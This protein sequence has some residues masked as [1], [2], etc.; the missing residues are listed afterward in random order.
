[1]YDAIIVGGGPA[2][3]SAALILG[4]CLRTVLLIDSGRPR[5]AWSHGVHGYLSRDGMDP[6]AFLETCH[7]ELKNYPTVNFLYAEVTEAKKPDGHFEI[8]TRDGDTFSGR[9]LLL[10]TGVVDCIPK[11]EGIASLYGRSVFNCPYCDAF[12]MRGKRILVYGQKERGKNLALTLRN[13]SEDVILVT[14]GPCELGDEDKALLH[15]NGITFHEGKIKRLIGEEGQLTHVEF[16]S[17]ET[18]A[19]DCMFFN[20]ESFL[21]SRLLD[22]LGCPFDEADGVPTGKYERT[23]VPG[24][25]VAGNILREVQLVIVAASQG[26]EAAFGINSAIMKENILRL[27]EEE[28]EKI[29]LRNGVI[30]ELPETKNIA[31]QSDRGH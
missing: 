10:A 14:H 6:L 22:Q 31:R 24:L 15:S 26:A 18:I 7:E 16:E 1:M 8:T 23:L 9:K 13:W 2:G 12:E 25:Y 30:S 17:G 21:R 28:S 27:P 5:N 4:R 11:L 3:L 19:R 29:M 20:T